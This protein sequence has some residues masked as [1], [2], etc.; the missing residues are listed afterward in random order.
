MFTDRIGDDGYKK[1]YDAE[2]IKNT[3]ITQACNSVTF[4]VGRDDGL[5]SRGNPLGLTLYEDL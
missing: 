3:R 1:V 2:I 5:A 4:D